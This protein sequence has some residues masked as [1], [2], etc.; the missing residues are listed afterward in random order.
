MSRFSLIWRTLLGLIVLVV[1]VAAGALFFG[2]VGA[3]IIGFLSLTVALILALQ[4]IRQF[5]ELTEGVIRIAS[6]D[7]R[8]RLGSDGPAELGRLARAV[9][10]FADRVNADISNETVERQR[11]ASILDSMREGVIVVDDQGVI[12]SAN[13][14]SIELLGS[15]VRV[16]SGML[17]ASLTNH[18]GVNGIVSATI[19]TGTTVSEEIELFDN[20]RIL[21]LL[22]TPFSSPDSETVRA[23]LL[24]TDLT[25]IRRLDTTRREF[26]SNASH[27]LR[28]PLAGIRASAETLER[29]ALKE[30]RA[31]KKFLQL[32]SE[33]V[34]RME[35]LIEEML[36][37]SRL[38]SGES[39]LNLVHASPK[40]LA[41]TALKR[42]AVIASESSLDLLS[43]VPV[44]LPLVMADVAK[45]ELVFSN[46][47]N[48]AIK[49]TPRGGTITISSWEDNG[50]VW[51]NVA[52]T[53]DGIAPEHMPHIFERFFKT[54]ASRAHTGAGLGLSIVRHIIESHNGSISATSVF[55]E[56]SKFGFTVPIID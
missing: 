23:L 43:T 51:F 52:D 3:V 46:L 7:R 42:F 6:I 55:G 4:L 39:K 16:Q 48:N 21:M 53:G 18:P 5:T 36:E 15:L 22:A 27:E 17:L 30:P 19:N 33:D 25:D 44:D 56:G 34:D 35:K 10:R 20:E 31:G 14:A 54:D 28:T 49:W 50:Y 2:V 45:I 13:P 40:D 24:L 12:E 11:L 9:N 32:I 38:E 37:L 29:G 1:L 41:E 26:V 8:H 47:I